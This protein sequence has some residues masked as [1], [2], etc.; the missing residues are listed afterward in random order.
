MAP[1]FNESLHSLPTTTTL[2]TFIQLDFLYL[3]FL[4]PS[5]PF[6]PHPTTPNGSY[7]FITV[8]TLP[9][10]RSPMTSMSQIQWLILCPFY[11][12]SVQQHLTHWFFLLLDGLS[13]HLARYHFPLAILIIHQLFCVLCSTCQ[14]GQ[15]QFFSNILYFHL[16][17]YVIASRTM[18]SASSTYQ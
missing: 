8:L 6:F 3:P 13:G 16:L 17:F 1:S 9:L 11:G 2:L 7:F 5:L 14:F 18:L 4:L 12:T 15:D 10:S